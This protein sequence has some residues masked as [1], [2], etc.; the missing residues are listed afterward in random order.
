[1]PPAK[2]KETRASKEKRKALTAAQNQEDQARP[3]VRQDQ[4][5]VTEDIG[6]EREPEEAIEDGSLGGGG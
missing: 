6:D 2:T 5:V 3:Q 4:P 1:M